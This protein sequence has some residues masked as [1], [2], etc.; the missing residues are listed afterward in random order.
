MHICM[1]NFDDLLINLRYLF[2]DEK[3]KYKYYFVYEYEQQYYIQI[4]TKFQKEI[5]LNKICIEYRLNGKQYRK[6]EKYK[7]IQ[8]S[9]DIFRSRFPCC[10]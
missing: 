2:D 4:S 9:P 6:N 10:S 8:V 5:N 7:S 3:I 1:K